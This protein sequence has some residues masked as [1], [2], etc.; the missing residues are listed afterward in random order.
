MIVFSNEN[1]LYA[2]HVF[3]FLVHYLCSCILE[4]LFA[5]SFPSL[6]R[7]R[8]LQK[9]NHN[10]NL[11]GSI[12]RIIIKTMRLRQQGCPTWMGKNVKS[13]IGNRLFILFSIRDFFHLLNFVC[14]KKVL[15]EGEQFQYTQFASNPLKFVKKRRRFKKK[16]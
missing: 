11:N 1:F 6:T 12:A 9:K 13:S 5:H 2:F 7:K 10:N 15:T 14:Y 8:Y 3:F 4:L 16:K